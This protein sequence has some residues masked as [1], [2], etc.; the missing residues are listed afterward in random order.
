MN[1]EHDGSFWLGL[2][3][4]GLLGSF[5]I[6]FLGTKEGKKLAKDLHEHGE[7]WVDALEE[8]L[9]EFNEKSTDVVRVG[10]KEETK[11][12]LTNQALKK[13]DKTLAHIE[14]LQERGRDTTSSIRKRLFKNAKKK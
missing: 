13:V 11:D 1:E 9:A 2:F 4:G 5:I 14:K 7:D 3:L 12:E 10:K 8:K 6:Y